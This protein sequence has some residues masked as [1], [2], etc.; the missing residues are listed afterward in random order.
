[1]ISDTPDPGVASISSDRTTQARQNLE[2]PNLINPDPTIQSNST[3]QQIILILVGLPGSGK[4]TFSQ[5]LISI[6]ENP[7][8][9]FQRKW[10]RASQDDAPNRRRQECE[11]VTRK[12]LR[13][14]YN[15]VIDR[16]NFDP[17]QR[18][19][20]INI[21]LSHNPPP[22]IYALTLTISEETLK[23]RLKYRPDHPTIPDL[24]TGLRVLGQMRSQYSPPIATQSEGFDKIYE[25]VE[26]DQPIDGIWT[27]AEINTVLTKIEAEGL[28][29]MG[30]RILI[31]QPVSNGNHHHHRGAWHGRTDDRSR[32]RQT[33]RDRG[34]SRGLYN[35][36]SRD[37]KID[38]ERNQSSYQ[39][40]SNWN[41]PGQRYDPSWNRNRTNGSQGGRYL[42]GASHHS[43]SNPG[44]S[45]SNG[46]Y[47]VQ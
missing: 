34:R 5:A 31:P 27:S 36:Q 28:M 20:F 13:D 11:Y 42:D 33:A 39:Y 7:F 12:A 43:N 17:I 4:S 45:H 8:N 19:H 46:L 2:G 25:L 15:V 35:G 18:S 26:T 32:V 29:E 14:G 10:V 24:E 44:N 16:V 23:K 30:E 40:Q 6:S 37:G 22:K 1:M 9:S 41:H 21:A 47:N 3:D 38:S